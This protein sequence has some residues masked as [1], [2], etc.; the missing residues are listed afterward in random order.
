MSILLNVMK[1]M[2]SPNRI[3]IFQIDT[4]LCD[5]VCQHSRFSAD[6][7]VSS[8]NKTCRHNI[9]SVLLKV[10]LNII[11]LPHPSPIFQIH[12]HIIFVEVVGIIIEFSTLCS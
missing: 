8:T 3:F 9:T 11:I 5:K 6:T 2:P 1:R 12:G 4:T 7:P 10:P